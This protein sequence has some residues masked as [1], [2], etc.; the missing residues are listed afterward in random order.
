MSSRFLSSSELARY[1]RA[2]G[3]FQPPALRMA[4][5]GSPSASM[6]EALP[7]LKACQ[8]ILRPCW[9][10]MAMHLLL[11]FCVAAFTVVRKIFLLGEAA[12]SQSSLR[13]QTPQRS[14]P[15]LVQTHLLETSEACDLFLRLA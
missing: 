7:L 13:Q 14:L 15:S 2:A 3:P 6:S 1:V 9:I 5:M 8:P 10:S 4:E 12:L 11:R